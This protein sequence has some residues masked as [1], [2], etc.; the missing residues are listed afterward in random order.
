MNFCDAVGAM[1][2]LEFLRRIRARA[3]MNDSGLHPASRG[4]C[5][6]SGIIPDARRK[7]PRTN[8]TLPPLPRRRA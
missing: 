3:L 8:W 4:C 5:N 7:R 6:T 2:R 1:H